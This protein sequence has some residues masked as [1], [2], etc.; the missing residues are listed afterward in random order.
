MVVLSLCGLM[1]NCYKK[2]GWYVCLTMCYQRAIVTTCCSVEKDES[3][4]QVQGAWLFLN[5]LHSFKP[6]PKGELYIWL[7]KDTSGVVHPVINFLYRDFAR[8]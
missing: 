8:E 1:P 2:D 6:N 5:N 4:F 3:Y 7:A